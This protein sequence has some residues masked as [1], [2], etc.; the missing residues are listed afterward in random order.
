MFPCDFQAQLRSS[1]KSVGTHHYVHLDGFNLLIADATAKLVAAESLAQIT[2][3]DRFNIARFDNPHNRVALLNYPNFFEDAFPA[4]HESWN[5]DL[6]PGRDC[7]NAPY[8]DAWFHADCN[9]TRREPSR[10]LLWLHPLQRIGISGRRG[11]VSWPLT[12]RETRGTQQWREGPARRD[13]L[14]LGPSTGSILPPGRRAGSH[15]VAGTCSSVN[16][17]QCL[18]AVQALSGARHGTT[19]IVFS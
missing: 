19:H 14:Q 7:F 3:S 4:L 16:D 17:Q 9:M 2:R 8:D 12:G 10:N 13:W 15:R 6:T 5:V 1:L 18:A 11:A